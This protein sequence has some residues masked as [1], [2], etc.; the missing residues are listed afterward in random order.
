M[1]LSSAR[2]PNTNFQTPVDL[3]SQLEQLSVNFGRSQKWIGCCHLKNNV[4][5]WGPK[6]MFKCSL[7]SIVI[8]VSIPGL[9]ILIK[10]SPTQQ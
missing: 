8:M 7:S 1:G 2:I 4:P 3:D 5:D 9:N 6:S 10:S